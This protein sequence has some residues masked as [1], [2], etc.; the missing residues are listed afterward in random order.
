MN[1]TLSQAFS[2]RARLKNKKQKYP[3]E[4]N[5]GLYRKQ[6]NFCVSLLRKEKKAHYN[7]ISLSVM[8]EQKK[9]YDIV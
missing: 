2:T 9:F 7:N 3:T 1:I 6:R 5:E 4:K 8:K